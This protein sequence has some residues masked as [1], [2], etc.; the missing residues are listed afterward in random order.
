MLQKVKFSQEKD[1]ICITMI[2]TNTPALSLNNLP[3]CWPKYR[4]RIPDITRRTTANI[5]AAKIVLR[6]AAITFDYNGVI[7]NDEEVIP[8]A[9]IATLE[10]HGY[11][12][13]EKEHNV[14]MFGRSFREGVAVFLKDKKNNDPIDIDKLLVEQNDIYI[15][16]INR[17]DPQHLFFP[18]AKELLT[19]V[20]SLALNKSIAIASMSTKRQI[21][22]GLR[23]IGLEHIFENKI[24]DE[25][26]VAHGK[27]NPECYLK[28]VPLHGKY[29]SGLK[30]AFE[31]SANG[32]RSAKTAGFYVIAV[33]STTPYEKL[34]LAGADIIIESIE[35]LWHSLRLILA[36]SKK[37]Y[38]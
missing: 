32:V 4:S 20:S 16:L 33:L 6:S 28:T 27:P 1:E 17:E 8:G 7:I 19:L 22:S 31:D 26:Q 15:E 12:M 11:I 9:T 21:V 29:G 35:G 34:Y 5:Y 25:S 37:S 18:G 13:S 30:I 3:K 36:A 23:I 24:I 14:C 2:M 10:R 38:F